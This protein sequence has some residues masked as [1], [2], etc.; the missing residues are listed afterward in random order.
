MGCLPDGAWVNVPPVQRPIPLVLGGLTRP[1]IE[2]A[3][4]LAEGHFVYAF[5]DVQETLGSMYHDLIEP[6]MA[7]PR[8]APGRFPADFRVGLM[9]VG[10]CRA[11]V[12]RGGRSCLPLPAAQVRGMGGGC[13]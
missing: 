11:R 9:G 7:A 13:G 10:R 2:R 1:A 4:R 12:A 8:P 5:G 3:A 6:A